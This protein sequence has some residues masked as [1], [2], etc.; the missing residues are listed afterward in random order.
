MAGA[1]AACRIEADQNRLAC[2][3][4]VERKLEEHAAIT[5]GAPWDSRIQ[6][7][8]RALEDD[9]L[10]R[11]ALETMRA[12]STHGAHG[13]RKT[14]G[15]AG[16]FHRRQRDDDPDQLKGSRGSSA[17]RHRVLAPEDR[18]GLELSD[19]LGRVGFETFLGGFQLARQALRDLTRRTTVRNQLPHP[20]SC[21]VEGKGGAI[22]EV[23]EE[24]L[25]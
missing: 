24:H 5:I 25:S 4:R 9:A 7:G 6:P 3:S 15:P 1:R 16:R 8:D 20:A 11:S 2:R 19:E 14:D 10:S 23:N 12:A 22:V 21:L 13:P 18:L 17:P